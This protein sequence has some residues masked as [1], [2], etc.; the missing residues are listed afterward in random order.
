MIANITTII[1]I[2]SVSDEIINSGTLQKG[3]AISQIDNGEGIQIYK[4]YNYLTSP[5]NTDFDP[6]DNFEAISFEEVNLY[7]SQS[8][9]KMQ[10][11]TCQKINIFYT[12]QCIQ[13][14]II[15]V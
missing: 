13:P 3:T 10:C 9:H 2:L 7:F 14:W 1:Y 6:N 4:Y 15:T 5:N 11:S 12:T 8:S